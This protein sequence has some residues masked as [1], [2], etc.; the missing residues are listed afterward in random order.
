LFARL[1]EWTSLLDATPFTV[2]AKLRRFARMAIDGGHAV[3]DKMLYRIGGISAVLGGILTQASGALHPVETATIFDPIVHMTEIAENP[4]WS[5]VFFGF[6]TGFLLILAGLTAIARSITDEGGGAAWALIARQVAVATT[7]VALV[8]FIVDGFAAKT[9][10]RAMVASGN[11]EAVVAAAGAIDR[12]G[13]MFFGQWTF[14]CWGVTPLL[15]GI[16]VLTG[17]STRKWLGVF[18]VLSGVTG[19]SVGIANGFNDFSLGLLPP[20]YAAVLIFNLWMIAMGILL[21]R[22]SR[23]TAA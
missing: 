11:N 6:S 18:P 5:A 2:S 20:F 19:I 22:K 4:L 9:V 14:L 3:S 1:D 13:R 8:F 21:I 23:T 7:A 10:A 17:A 16:A 15:F 12:V